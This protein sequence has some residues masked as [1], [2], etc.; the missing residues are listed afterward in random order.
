MHIFQ[1]PMQSERFLD[2]KSYAGDEALEPEYICPA[3]CGV[4]VDPIECSECQALY[5]S[6]CLTA[7][8]MNCLKGCGAN[9]Y[10]KVHRLV[11]NNLM[12]LKFTCQNEGCGAKFKYD[13]FQSHAQSCPKKPAPC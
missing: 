8:D 11:M 7:P 2:P 6:A 9:S 12:K 5:C 1:L 3:C 10:G 4:A 13:E